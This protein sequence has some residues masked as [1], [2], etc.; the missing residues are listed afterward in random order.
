MREGK[1]MKISGF[2]CKR[3]ILR[4]ACR[5]RLSPMHARDW[6]RFLRTS[7][8]VVVR[9]RPTDSLSSDL[10][11]DTPADFSAQRATLIRPTDRVDLLHHRLP[12]SSPFL[13]FARR[14]RGK[15]P[16]SE[17]QLTSKATFATY[18]FLASPRSRE[19]S[20]ASRKHPRNV[21]R[22]NIIG[23]ERD[24]REE[25]KRERR[26]RKRG[27]EKR[28]PSSSMAGRDAEWLIVACGWETR[29]WLR[30]T[31][32]PGSPSHGF[33]YV[34]IKPLPDRSSLVISA[35]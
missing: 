29:D 31:Y 19:R 21:L 12:A 32:R 17:T 9:V 33:L 22:T 20:R 27:G 6:L 3:Q 11:S 5:G 34:E 26:E 2:S 30:S 8:G 16:K 35:M 7:R 15:W 23:R 25:R 10:F 1:K 24:I 14:S 4:V 13:P 18:P 28:N